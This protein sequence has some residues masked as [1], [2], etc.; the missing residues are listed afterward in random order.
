MT[1]VDVVAHNR[2]AWDDQVRSGDIWTLG[3]SPEAVARARAGDLSEVV[4]IGY[5]PI[6]REWLPASLR[7]VRIL[8]LASGGGQQGPLLAAAGA[9]VTV[10]DNS[11]LQLERDRD[12]A[13]REQL[14]VATVQGDMR[15]LS[16]FADASFDVVLNPVSNVFCPE[17]EPVWRECFRVLKPGGELLCGF[18]NPDIY[19][20][21]G[22]ILDER[23]ELVVRFSLP[24]SDTG[25]LTEEELLALG[26]STLQFSHTMTEQIGGQIGAGFAIVGFDEAPHHSNATAKYMPGYYATRARKPG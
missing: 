8:G 2:K 25:S 12:V 6:V 17:L 26:D 19:I 14:E 9:T 18:V 21:D 15:D 4:L 11:P 10:F 5:K 7:G 1:D 22:D 23:G 20:F 13:A 3:A 24:Y 16:A